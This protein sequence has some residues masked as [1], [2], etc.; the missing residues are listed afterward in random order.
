VIIGGQ[1]LIAAS[2]PRSWAHACCWSARSDWRAVWTG[3]VPS[4]SLIRAAKA[5][6]EIRTGRRFGV[7]AGS[8]TVDMAAVREYLQRKVQEI[9]QPTSP[10]ALAREGVDVALGPAAFETPHA[11]RVGGVS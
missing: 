6:H 8:C 9:Y 4:K 10:D 7:D 11:V 2:S 1:G 5:A 3:C